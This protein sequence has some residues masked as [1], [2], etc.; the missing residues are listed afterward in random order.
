MMTTPEEKIIN[1][2]TKPS[3]PAAAKKPAAP[4]RGKMLGEIRDYFTVQ[5]EQD[6]SWNRYPSRY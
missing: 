6:D 1:E 3:V 5:M 4:P 2:V